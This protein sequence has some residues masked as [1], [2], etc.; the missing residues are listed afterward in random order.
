MKS[1]KAII[2]A[3]LVGAFF[4]SACGSSGSG[5]SGSGESS[6]GRSGTDEGIKDGGTLF[7]LDHSTGA[8]N[9]DPQRIYT[10]ADL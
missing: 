5:G 9:L 1:R 2:G 3:L 6:G 7:I 4:V 10:G 8:T